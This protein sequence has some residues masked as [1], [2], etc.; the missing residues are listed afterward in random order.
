MG[1]Q[2]PTNIHPKYSVMSNTTAVKS[3]EKSRTSRA[4]TQKRPL[5][6]RL[7]TKAATHPFD[8][9]AWVER[10]AVVGSLE[11]K[12]F[13]QKGVEF[14]DF[15]SENAVAI[16]VSKYFRGKLGTPERETSLRQMISRVSNQ[17]YA[18]GLDFGHFSTAEEAKVFQ[19]E[20]NY[21]LL[22]QLGSFNSP[23]WFN[24]GTTPKPQCSACFILSVEDS[25]VSI[26]EWIR[27]EGM[28]FKG[29]SGSGINLSTLRSKEES[30]SAG[31]RASGPVSFMRGADS[32]A[33]MIKSGGTTRR[34]AK[35]VIL[36]IDHPDVME[37]IRCKMEEEKKI[38][39]L[40]DAGYNMAEL[41][42][43]AWLSIQFQNANNSVRFSD[44]F[45]RAA[46]EDREWTTRY[47]KSGEPAKTYRARDILRAVAEAAWACGDPGVQYDTVIN[48][49]H[50]CPNS[51]RIN[52]SNPCFTGDTCI[53]TD[54]GLIEIER[55]FEMTLRGE[56]FK[57]FTHNL[58]GKE[59]PTDSVSLTTPTQVMMTGFNDVYELEFESGLSVKAT[60]N[61]RFFTRNR[62]MVP[63]EDLTEKDQVLILNQAIPFSAAPATL[64]INE[65]ALYTSGWGGRNTKQFERL[66][67]PTV[68]TAGFAEYVGFL[69]GDGC[70]REAS[71]KNHRLSTASLVF[72]SEEESRE[73]MPKFEPVLVGMGISPQKVSMPNGTVQLR[74]N[75]T[76][77]VRF[78]KQIGVKEAKA[79]EKRMPA[80]ILNAPNHIASAFLRGLFTADGCAYDGA[81][82]RYVGLGSS[83]RELLKDTQQVLLT[84]GISSRIYGGDRNPSAEKFRYT[85]K[86]GEVVTYASGPMYDLRIS[87]GAIAAFRNCIGF[88]TAA[89]QAKL[90]GII[91][92]HA[93]Y[94]TD[95]SAHLLRRTYL[96][97][98]PTYNLTEPQNHSYIANGCVVANC[99][100]YMHLDN[101][102]CNLASI[103]LLHFLAPDGT[104]KVREFRHVVRLFIT[105]QEILVDGSSYPTEKIAENAHRFRQLG[106]G[107]AN[108]GALLM[109]KGLAYDSEEGRALAETVSAL[110]SG[111]AYRTSAEI[112]GKLGPFEGYAENREPMQKVIGKHRAASY[113]VSAGFL[114]DENLLLAAQRSWDEAETAGRKYGFRNSQVS[115]IA[116]T[117]TIAF[118]MDCDTTGIEPDFSLV[119]MKQLVGG[120]WM[121]IVNRTIPVA[122][123]K[124]GYEE[125]QIADIVAWI[126]EHG[127]AENA[128]HLKNEHLSVFDC[129]V[130]SKEGTRVIPWQGHVR[131]VA[132]VQ[133]FISGAISK[134]FNMDHDTSVEEI[135]DAYRMAWHMGIKAFAVYRDGS[136]ATQP[137]QTEAGKNSQKKSAVSRHRLPATHL[138]ET[139]KFSVAGHDGYITYS[140]Y[141]D[142]TLAEMFIRIAKQGST[143][144]GLLDAFAIGVSLALQYGVPLKVLARKFIHSRFEPAGFTENPDIRVATS[145][146]DYMFRYLALRFLPAEDLAEFGMQPTAA[147]PITDAAHELPAHAVSAPTNTAEIPPSPTSAAKTVLADTVCRKCGGM[148]VRTGTC[149]TCLSCGT[150]SGG[151]S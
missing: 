125:T 39:A 110:M 49:W 79:P 45:M 136:K 4:K 53:A 120:G 72:G 15:W 11:R 38:R 56:K 109:A 88:G 57:V 140:A 91:K 10:D 42:N 123:A 70:V 34:A 22:H 135:A 105:A 48:S 40:M 12:V 29:G 2:R 74:A 63:A 47:R 112:A 31:G 46:E 117:G 141:E 107:F 5:V 89:K 131:M 106:L 68:W 82:H 55:L 138:S 23:V 137:L 60:P 113:R 36:D 134:T 9:V 52:G 133:P 145:I 128:P 111:E 28:I 6:N 81:K 51:G 122:L 139:H 121:K 87:G 21:V 35:M 97:K 132:A 142:G 65:A 25:M 80:S 26:L 67:L 119:K 3:S 148:M 114:D 7:F 62:G 85:K 50:T 147:A 13:E 116:P 8:E 1:T 93:F 126:G 115:V 99:S 102:A 73:L 84:F 43:E 92:N 95:D 146:L 64:P 54:R 59:K 127:V 143:L 44:E 118:I 96:G 18:W 101:S 90:D 32:V 78:L 100:E 69:I 150:S 76:P 66:S 17:V 77:F 151:C 104:F 20:L 37:F 33:G 149:Q 124:L 71:D 103:N 30:L 130:K 58:T 94:Q 108:L 75:R 27:T 61:H 129:A 14:P 41:N 144:S 24:V 98:Q 83:S 16:A 86:N 19:D